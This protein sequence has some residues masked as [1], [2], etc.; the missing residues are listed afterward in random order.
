MGDE[1]TQGFEI[2]GT[3]PWAAG[4]QHLCE[5]HHGYHQQ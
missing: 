2:E 5:R 4:F 3:V 1:I